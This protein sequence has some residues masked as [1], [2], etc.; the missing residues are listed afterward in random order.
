MAS[1]QRALGPVFYIIALLLSALGVMMLIPA[2]YERLSQEPN[3]GGFIEAA[4]VT[5]TVSIAMLLATNQPIERFSIKQTFL[6]TTLSWGVLGCFGSLPFLFSDLNMSLIDALFESVSGLTTTGA[7]I[8]PSLDQTSSGILLWR[9]LLHWYGGVGIIVMALAILPVLGIGGMQ[10][11][12]TE[13]SDRSDKPFTKVHE[14]ASGI[15][16]TYFI[17]TIF[18]ALLFLSAGMEGFDAIC[19]AMSAIATG[20]FSTRNGSLGSFDSLNILWIGILSMI[21]A[22]LPLTHYIRLLYSNER[23]AFFDSQVKTFLI[24]LVGAIALLTFWRSYNESLSWDIFTHTA[25]NAISIITSSGFSSQDYSQWGTFPIILFFIFFFIGGCTGS[26]SGSIKIF[27]WQILIKGLVIQILRMNHP[28]RVIFPVYQDKKVSPEV[29]Q[30]V[31]NY[32]IV[33]LI[34]M[35]GVILVFT[36]LGLDLLTSVSAAAAAITNV[37]PGLG[38]IIGPEG[39]YAPLPGLTKAILCGVMIMGRLEVFTVLILLTVNF[40]KN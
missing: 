27:R 11:F 6:L 31:M 21:M 29:I 30:S 32:V 12:H 8:I 3:W 33:V 7:T 25:F 10:L 14:I 37:G 13:S 20:G 28:H 38:P 19:H 24:L 23:K 17:L 16:A 18:S 9:A 15:A 5:L 4:L 1:S 35:V 39:T 36:F 34:S 2:L 40:W 22:S 26:T